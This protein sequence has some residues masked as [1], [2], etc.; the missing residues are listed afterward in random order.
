M[1]EPGRW[2]LK[3]IVVRS[4]SARMSS[5]ERDFQLSMRCP[6]IVVVRVYDELLPLSD[7]AGCI[8]GVAVQLH[9][10]A[11]DF[12]YESLI[13]CQYNR[14]SGKDVSIVSKKIIGIAH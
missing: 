11:I 2:R 7:R 4:T 13:K 8:F 14:N 10:P 5:V 12:A 3:A 9:T 1:D 6:D